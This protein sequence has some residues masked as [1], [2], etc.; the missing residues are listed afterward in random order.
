M[1]PK[2]KSK[3]G[4]AALDPKKLRQIASQGGLARSRTYR[5]ARQ[6]PPVKASTQ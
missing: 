1:K 3:Q 5:E 2:P 4:F 6:R